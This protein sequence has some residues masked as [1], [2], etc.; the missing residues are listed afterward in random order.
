M[1][2]GW[3]MKSKEYKP[4]MISRKSRYPGQVNPS[5]LS[6]PSLKKTKANER[7]GLPS[8]R[9]TTQ[10]QTPLG[11]WQPR[12]SNSKCPLVPHARPWKVRSHLSQ[13]L[14]QFRQMADR[15][16]DPHRNHQRQ[17]HLLHHL[18]HLLRSRAGP[19][20]FPSD[21]IDPDGV[22]KPLSPLSEWV[23]QFAKV[24][25]HLDKPSSI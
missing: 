24:G 20:G 3:G 19:F 21:P 5:S 23:V 16:M 17:R 15:R 22:H 13:W 4:P 14:P 8:D 18:Y 9:P 7:N 11:S 1:R 25:A 2:T 6:Y 12:I 10:R